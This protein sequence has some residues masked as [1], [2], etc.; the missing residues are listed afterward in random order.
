MSK[1]AQCIVKYRQESSLTI[2][3][4][5]KRAVKK[6]PQYSHTSWSQV[7]QALVEDKPETKK[8][9]K[10]HQGPKQY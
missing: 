5:K 4:K 9:T 8:L 6:T 3:L 7:R 2:K 1:G 10:L